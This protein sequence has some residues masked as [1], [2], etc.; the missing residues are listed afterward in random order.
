MDS[1]TTIGGHPVRAVGSP[2]VTDTDRGKA[3]LFDGTGDGLFIDALP[4]AGWREFTVEVLFRPDA[5]GLHEQRFVHL[6]EAGT[7]N[8]I[9]L[10]TRL[11]PDGTWYAD[12]FMK[13]GNNAKALIDPNNVHP[14]GKWYVLSLVYDGRTMRHYVNGAYEMSHDIAFEPLRD[15]TTSVG[16]RQNLVHWFKGA[17][18]TL[19]F[20]PRALEADEL[21][22]P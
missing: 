1:T 14:S 8:R 7:E 19:R 11:N 22:M 18:K 3:I 21:L 9:M 5:G 4:V 20:T 13:S 16:V 6:Q 17:V 15:G 10:E 2:R 12:S